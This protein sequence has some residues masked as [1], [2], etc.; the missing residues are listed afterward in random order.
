MT[1]PD[2]AAACMLGGSMSE[3]PSVT[4]CPRN[5]VTVTTTNKTNGM[6]C[7]YETLRI[8]ALEI[9]HHVSCT[10]YAVVSAAFEVS[11]R[12]VQMS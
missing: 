7:G 8:T 11:H 10:A 2:I 4:L 12:P 1:G 6:H 9:L 5:L 3:H